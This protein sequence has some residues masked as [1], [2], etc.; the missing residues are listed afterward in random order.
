[1]SL[2]SLSLSCSQAELQKEYFERKGLVFH[3]RG[4]NISSAEMAGGGGGGDGEE[5]DSTAG[6][7][8]RASRGEVALSVFIY[9]PIK[10]LRSLSLHYTNVCSL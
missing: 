6:S 3:G 5:M 7:A 4:E 10:V 1:M 9:H 8:A 2:V